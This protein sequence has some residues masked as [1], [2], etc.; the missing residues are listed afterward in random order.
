[1]RFAVLVSALLLA[2]VGCATTRNIEGLGP[3]AEFLRA[4]AQFDDG[5]YFQAVQSL[6]LFRNNHP[7][8]D[9]VDDAIFLLGR[10]HDELGE[11]VLAQAEYDRLLADYPQSEHREAGEF[12]RAMSFFDSSY[13]ASRDPEPLTMAEEAFQ[14]YLRHYPDGARRS[15]AEARV[16]DCRDRLAD[17]A[18]LNGQTYERL[19]HPEAARIYYQKS[20][21]L[22][23]D[24][25]RA[26][27]ALLGWARVEA[28]MGNAEKAREL[29]QQ[30]LDK[31][32]AEQAAQSKH[33]RR[34]REEAA[35]KLA[36]GDSASGGPR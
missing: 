24:S 8:S 5:R 12:A 23:A 34:V 10:A 14:S 11:H 35:T 36:G 13:P 2:G 15:D 19:R 7:G 17:K 31:I 9:R 32:S 18:Y 4:K 3:E 21:A 22:L 1:M 26:P 27:E 28:A 33:L 20:L 25:K 29:Y 6:D 30:V 16:R